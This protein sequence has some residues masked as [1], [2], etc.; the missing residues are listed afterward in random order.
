M[1]VDTTAARD[2]RDP[3]TP[4]LGLTHIA[5]HPTFVF[6][7]IFVLSHMLENGRLSDVVF[8]GGFT[9]FVWI[10]CVHMDPR[11]R[12][13]P[14]LESYFAQTSLLPFAAIASGRNRIALGEVPLRGVLAGVVVTGILF[15]FHSQL[16]GGRDGRPRPFPP[17]RARNHI[18]NSVP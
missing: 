5:R 9:A 7:G 17:K 10:G 8:F 11:K 13:I 1:I 14:E 18:H 4:A 6:F 15:A 2:Q 16:F 12:A 3:K